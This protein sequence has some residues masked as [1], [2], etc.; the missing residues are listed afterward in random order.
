MVRSD[1]ASAGVAFALD[2]DTGLCDVVL[3]TGSYG[4]GES[5]VG[6]K[7][8]GDPDEVFLVIW[9]PIFA[10]GVEDDSNV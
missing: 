2:P 4:L 10:S 8:K 6:G 9:W 7:E 3:I 1:M 5:V